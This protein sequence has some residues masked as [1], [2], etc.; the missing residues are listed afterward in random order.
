[1]SFCTTKSAADYQLKSGRSQ[2]AQMAFVIITD[3][4]EPGSAQKPAVLLADHVEKIPPE[5]FG[6]A[7]SNFGRM[8]TMA[9]LVAKAQGSSHQRVWTE[10]HSP[11]N[12]GKC[13]RLGKSPTD[14]ALETY[15]APGSEA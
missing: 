13:R 11:A 12:A 8:I 3:V 10:T 6:V 9:S 2:R 15:A 14:E 4:L 5:E 7:P 1:M